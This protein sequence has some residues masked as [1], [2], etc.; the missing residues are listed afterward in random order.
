MRILQYAALILSFLLTGTFILYAQSDATSAN[1]K[2]TVR[3]LPIVTSSTISEAETDQD[4]FGYKMGQG[5][6]NIATAWTD[7]PQQIQET[8][9]ESNIFVGATV[10]LIKG[11]FTGL[12]RG[13]TGAVD[14]ATFGVPPYDDAKAEPR[15]TVKDPE[16]DGYKVNLFNW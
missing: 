5:V 6:L 1:K 15:Y 2:G 3:P 10:G 11:I 4:T 16:K 8:S 7:I 14:V 12:Y 13:V 9:K